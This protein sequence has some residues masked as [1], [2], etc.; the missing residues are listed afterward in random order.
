MDR[1]A[2][3]KKLPQAPGIYLMK[4]AQGRVLYVGKAANL[5]RRVSSY[6]LRP[7]DSRIE[8]LVSEISKI[9]YEPTD[10][11]IE[12]LILE[13]K[14]IKELEPP[15]NVREKDD[16]SFLYVV[17][18]KEKFPRIILARG[19]EVASSK[20]RTVSSFG[21]FTSASSIRSAL[22]II[23]K[24]FPW[25][26]HPSA[27]LGASPADKTRLHPERSRRACFDYEVGLCPG[28]CAGLV[29]R[30]EYLR[31]VRNIRLFFQ[32]KKGQV[33]KNLAAEMRA[34]AKAQEFERAERV[35]RRIFALQH[36]Q[37]IA[38]I[39]PDEFQA[40]SSKL[41]VT[42]IEGYDVSNISGTDAV[43]AMVVFE[44]DHPAKSQYR[45]FRIRTILGS[46]DT[47][48]LQEVLRRRFAHAGEA[49]PPAGGWPL[50]D[51]ILI[52]GGAGQVS[53]AK[54]VLEE[55]GLKLPVVG[56]AKGPERKRNDLVGH[57]PAGFS[58][59]TLVRVRDEAHRFA[60]GYHKKVRARRFLT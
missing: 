17:I 58:L 52:D 57:L 51:L 23:R 20:L 38:L 32:G 30:P 8:S 1:S 4:D 44:N 56:L 46:D 6:F 29:S 25:N 33:L 22:R 50:P 36:I 47:G 10:T 14:R 28:T 9:D 27:E 19:K 16:K 26:T 45:K 15:F 11:A 42:R 13:S 43:G 55:T 7:H 48:M 21:P 54:K 24:I 18:T 53:A 60:I 5:K 12:A 39:S 40:A 3:Y 31:S 2:L 34:A 41:R 59:P 37:D 35:K 49:D